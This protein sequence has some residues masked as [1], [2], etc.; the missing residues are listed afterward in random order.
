M[1]HIKNSNKKVNLYLR[2]VVLLV[3]EY[4]KGTKLIIPTLTLKNPKEVKP[5]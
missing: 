4:K 5:E 1:H 3:V 2:I